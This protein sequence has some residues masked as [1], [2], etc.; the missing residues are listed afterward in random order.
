MDIT[1]KRVLILGAGGQIGFETALRIA[2]L[3]PSFLCIHSLIKEDI[4]NLEYQVKQLSPNTLTFLS[5]GDIFLLNEDLYFQ[6]N[7]LDSK[8]NSY[9]YVNLDC[10]LSQNT[11]IYKLSNLFK[12]DIII[13][14]TN[15]STTLSNFE[16]YL[17]G[18]DKKQRIEIY[19][20][21]RINI[22]IESLK[23]FIIGLK[24]CFEELD[25]S[26]YI[27]VS[28]TAL[29]GLGLNIDYTH[30]DENRLHLSKNMWNKLIFSGVQ[31]QML[32]S[33]ARTV[34]KRNK[35]VKIV[36]PATLVGF[37]K[38]LFKAVDK[39]HKVRTDGD[40]ISIFENTNDK[41]KQFSVISS[42][43]NSVY[44]LQELY[45]ISSKYQMQ[46]ISKEEV[47]DEI[48]NNLIGSSNKDLINAMQNAS[49]SSSF[50]GRINVENIINQL[51]TNNTKSYES[52]ATGNLGP[53][54]SKQLLELN[55]IK[56]VYKQETL[57][58]FCNSVKEHMFDSK[59]IEVDNDLLS[60]V[61]MNK[62]GL[63]T[64]D[65][66]MFV[67]EGFYKEY[68]SQILSADLNAHFVDLRKAQISFWQERLRKLEGKIE[69]FDNNFN[70]GE[71]LAYLLFLEGKGN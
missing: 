13:D 63:I 21:L 5:W 41:H 36:V 70:E 33:L 46:S 56:R 62:L 61:F 38:F 20:S 68:A 23:A 18:I 44:S 28:T 14:A 65:D 6:G 32:W 1:G 60:I 34:A 27:K 4:I 51:V 17:E 71:V 26:S 12:P 10:L 15:S 53:K 40:K 8:I 7:I 64:D 9:N 55:I 3:S 48:V 19:D 54:I 49:L 58:S 69:K 57:V 11:R 66:N 35:Q 30:G 45:L 2:T 67:S 29:G 47:V 37:Q 25:L 22:G 24:G 59:L 39:M 16:P 50:L 52:I 42:G 31:H 43:E